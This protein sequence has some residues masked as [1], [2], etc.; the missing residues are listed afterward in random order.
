MKVK[1][2]TLRH[3]GKNLNKDEVGKLPPQS[4]VLLVCEERDPALHRAVLRARL[5][6]GTTDAVRDVLPWLSDVRLIHAEGKKMTFIG[7]ERI[8]CAEYGQTWRVEVE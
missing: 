8:G 5:L 3:Q 6:D 2:R 1:V 4:G 7:T